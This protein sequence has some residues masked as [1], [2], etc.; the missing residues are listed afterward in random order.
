MPLE[1]EV[2]IG[3]LHLNQSLAAGGDFYL[4]KDTP[5]LLSTLST[6]KSDRDKQGG[7]GTEDSLS[8][9]GARTLPFK[10][11]IH[12]SSQESRKTME[13]SLMQAIGLSAMQ[14]FAGDDGYKLVLIRDE[15]GIAKQIYAKVIDPPEFE[16]LDTAMPEARKFSFVMYAKDPVLYAQSLNEKLG[17]ESFLSTTLTAQEGLLPTFR[18]GVT[19]IIQDA[20]SASVT[21]INGGTFGTPPVMI[22]EGPTLNP[23]L[24]NATTD[25]EMDFSSGDGLTLLESETLTINVGNQTIVKRDGAGVET[26][27][28]GA[29]TLSSDWIFLEPGA[30]LLTLRDDTPD[31]LFGQLI[32]Q[33]RDA[34]M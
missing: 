33:W 31:A 32:V 2:T 8:Q 18:E 11:E 28:S 12:A 15:D 29:L 5:E 26:D 6:R 25:R 21:A 24:K 10:G 17:P 20:F 30:N 4:L 7:H 16:V 14:D 23:I 19:P 27:E 9:Y 34:W 22:I 13:K 3:T 1:I